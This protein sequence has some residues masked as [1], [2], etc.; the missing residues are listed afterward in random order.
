VVGEQHARPFAQLQ[1]GHAH[2]SIVD[3]E[4]APRAEDVREVRHVRGDVTAGRV[5]VVELLERRR[6][7]AAARSFP[8]G[9]LRHDNEV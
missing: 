7:R 5:H 6:V 1:H 8:A 4:E 9:F 2:A 3:G